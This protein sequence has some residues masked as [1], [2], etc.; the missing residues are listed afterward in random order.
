[1]TFDEL[2]YQNGYQGTLDDRVVLEDTF[3]PVT[4]VPTGNKGHL[5]LEDTSRD[6]F[7]VIR[8]DSKDANGVYIGA[9]GARNLDGTSSGIH[10]RGAR[11]R[12]NLTKQ[13]IDMWVAHVNSVKQAL[14]DFE[15]S[16]G[17]VIVAISDTQPAPHATLKTLWVEPISS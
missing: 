12:M 16:N 1:M 4:P 9:E 3:I 15:L 17:A 14:E 13:D 8:Y 10:P 2:E 6:N 7:E 5:V 11:V